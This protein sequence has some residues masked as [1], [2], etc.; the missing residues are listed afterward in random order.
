MVSS[1]LLLQHCFN[2]YFFSCSELCFPTRPSTS[3]APHQAISQNHAQK[4]PIS[5]SVL[6][7]AAQT[8]LHPLWNVLL[9]VSESP[10][11]QSSSLLQD[12]GC[13]VLSLHVVVQVNMRCVTLGHGG[14]QGGTCPKR[15]ASP[16]VLQRRSLQLNIPSHSSG[17]GISHEFVL[18]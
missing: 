8:C 10:S 11:S 18:G 12:L 9:W 5:L 1:R 6:K 2:M 17:P 4:F 13:T 15:L 3:L 14:A 16:Y 7:P